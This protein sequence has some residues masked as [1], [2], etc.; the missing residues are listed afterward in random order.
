[1]LILSLGELHFLMCSFCSLGK[2]SAACC[3]GTG[4]LSP[5]VHAT[6]RRNSY[7]EAKFRSRPEVDPNPGS[8]LERFWDHFGTIF[9]CF[10]FVLH[11]CCDCCMHS[12]A[13]CYKQQRSKSQGVI[14]RKQQR[15]SKKQLLSSCHVALKS[16]L[17][18]VNELSGPC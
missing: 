5:S 2:V 15:A 7:G 10:L 18:N 8:C 12:L 16:S 14:K 17:A 3:A 6:L 9:V 11:I 4:H 1:M 13:A